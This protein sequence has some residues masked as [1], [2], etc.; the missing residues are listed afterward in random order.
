MEAT[1][2]QTETSLKILMHSSRGKLSTIAFYTD[3]RSHRFKRC[4]F[5]T[6]NEVAKA[7]LQAPGFWTNQR[8]T[9]G[10]P[11]VVRKC[12]LSCDKWSWARLQ[13]LS[14]APS[15]YIGIKRPPY[16]GIFHQQLL[17]FRGAHKRP[18]SS[19]VL[20]QSGIIFSHFFIYLLVIIIWTQP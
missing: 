13:P 9:S 18:V 4:E 6:S 2:Q 19:C 5:R 14:W 12:H 1:E 10:R 3:S 7:T 17:G 20:E 15:S 11:L 16:T 8:R